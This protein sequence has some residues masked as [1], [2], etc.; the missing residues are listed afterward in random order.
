MVD[1]GKPPRV[2]VYNTK[3]TLD[4][5]SNMSMVYNLINDQAMLDYT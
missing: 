3:I 2:T 1:Q 5:V 4:N